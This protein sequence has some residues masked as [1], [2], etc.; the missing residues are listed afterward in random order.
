MRGSAAASFAT[1]LLCSC[2]SPGL[3]PGARAPVGLHGTYASSRNDLYP[4]G[5]AF[6]EVSGAFFLGSLARGDVSRITSDGDESIFYA[7]PRAPGRSTLGM[8]VDP[9]ARRLWVC[10]LADPT[11]KVGSV[12]VLDI[13][14]GTLLREV[15]LAEAVERASCNDIA[16]DAA[17]VAYVTDRERAA[18]YRIAIDGDPVVWSS[19]A[20]LA[21]R[22]VGLNGIAITA[23]GE[24][25]LVTHYKPATLL[26]IRMREPG[27]VTEVEMRGDAF[28]GAGHLVSGADGIR[29]LGH[30]LYVAFDR[31]VMRLTS[32]DDWRSAT[33]ESARA[34]QRRGV[35]AIVVARGAPYT[36]DGQTARFLLGLRPTLPFQL[37]FFDPARFGEPRRAKRSG[38]PR[39][40]RRP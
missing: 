5:A 34:P 26:R 35:T 15:D 9:A 37:A 32:H 8:A 31:R 36:A 18:I 23:D 29:L 28:A 20:L 12:W 40:R 13:D 7:G 30:Q 6:D 19:H 21:P 27:D 10:V 25:M 4:E 39:T 24:T 3:V 11:S 22:W 14:D 38:R 2:A 17:G 1:A 33:V 16:L